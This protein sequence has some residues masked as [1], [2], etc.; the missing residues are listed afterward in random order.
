MHLFIPGWYIR[1][2]TLAA[3]TTV[4]GKIHRHAHPMAILAGR[5]EVADGHTAAILSAGYHGVS[6]PGVKRAVHCLEDTIFMTIH[7]NP[8]D[9]RDLAAIEAEHIEPEDPETQALMSSNQGATLC[10]G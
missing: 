3:G 5:A 4:V 10:R 1:V 8:T 6:Q 9:T 7:A 2:L